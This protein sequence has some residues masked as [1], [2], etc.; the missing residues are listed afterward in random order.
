MRDNVN[1][2]KRDDSKDSDNLDEYDDGHSTA[3]SPSFGGGDSGNDDDSDHDDDDDA[4]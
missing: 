1:K 4:V 3:G 2:V